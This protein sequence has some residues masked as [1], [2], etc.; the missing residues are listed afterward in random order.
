MG[1]WL[2]AR[3][4]YVLYDPMV[5]P[6]VHLVIHTA[7]MKTLCGLYYHAHDDVDPFVAYR[8]PTCVYCVGRSLWRG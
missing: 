3:G 8:A 4:D 6:L 7:G 5:C 1:G 2:R